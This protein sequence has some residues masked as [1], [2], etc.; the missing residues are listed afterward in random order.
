MVG[1][2]G[3]Y[4]DLSDTQWTIVAPLLL[5]AK[6][7][8]RPRT[9]CV[10]SVVDAIFYLP[11][12]GCQWWRLLPRCFPPW[13]TV[14]HYFRAWQRQGVW[15]RLHR[16]VY[17]LARAAAGRSACP[18]LV[19]MDGQ[20]IKTTERGGVRGFDGHKL[21]RGRKRHILMDT[22]GLIITSRVEPANVPDQRA[23]ARLLAGLRPLVCAWLSRDMAARRRRVLRERC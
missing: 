6:V 8:G 19:I 20:S 7:G 3:F 12:E 14:H 1:T 18:S 21:V 15:V 4:T 9:T 10:R 2:S 13:S 16:A 5:A 22:L 23:R 11:R 17:K